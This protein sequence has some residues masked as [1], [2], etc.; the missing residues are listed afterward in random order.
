V[1][2]NT[3]F[4]SYWQGFSG[5]IFPRYC[6][7][8]GD[9]LYNNENMLCLGCFADLPR[10]R[11]HHDEENE[12][13]QLF[14]GRVPLEYATSFMYFAKGSRFQNI[15]HELKYNDQRQIGTAMGR[16]FGSELINTPFATADIIIPVPLHPARLKFRGY[17]QSQLIASGIGEILRLPVETTM[18]SRVMDTRSQT[19]KSRYERW[20]N[21][22]YIF[23]C[24]QPEALKEK[25]V[26][27]VDDVITTGATLEACASCLVPIEG[28]KVS[29]VSL[30]FAKLG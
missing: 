8:C 16:M 25:H 4:Q 3:A 24:E 5:L 19:Q 22:R 6:A 20:E 29:V 17:N 11:F 1:S 13:A 28:I 7:A 12:V 21:V 27:L 2:L 15:L 10:T 26:M 30:A 9:A 18:L 23:H 14:W